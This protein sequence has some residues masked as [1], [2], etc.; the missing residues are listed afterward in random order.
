MN[1][2][3]A[4]IRRHQENADYSRMRSGLAKSEF[5]CGT[6]CEKTSGATV[7]VN[8]VIMNAGGALMKLYQGDADCKS[9][10][11]CGT[12]CE[13][14][15]GATGKYKQRLLLDHFRRLGKHD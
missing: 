8:G 12:G 4:L 2:G 9:E 1:G 7:Y 15:S 6:G 11:I 14:T 3:G 5:I 13:K 10:F